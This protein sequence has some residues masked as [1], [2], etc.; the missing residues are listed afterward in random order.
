M[1]YICSHCGY[2]ATDL[3]REDQIVD[4]GTTLVC[5]E[6]RETTVVLLLTPGQHKEYHDLQVHF[7]AIVAALIEKHSEEIAEIA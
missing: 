5:D 6:C 4:N 1:T 3:L 7:R 2:V